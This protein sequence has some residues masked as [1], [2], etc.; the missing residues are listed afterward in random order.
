MGRR[1]L[2]LTAIACILTAC[3]GRVMTQE[4]F[5]DV[6]IGT[7]IEEVIKIYGRPNQINDVPPNQKSYEYLERIQLKTE[8]VQIRRYYF[9]TTDGKVTGKF[10]RF[11]N[12][13]GYEQIYYDPIYPNS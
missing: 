6:S 12:P 8:T 1:A 7:P 10:V 13:P 9:V 5:A 3:G 2:L 4:R 11:D